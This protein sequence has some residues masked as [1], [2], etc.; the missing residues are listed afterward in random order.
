MYATGDAACWT[1]DGEI[2]LAGRF[3]R[4]VKLRGLRVEPQE[5]AD[6]IA[7]YPGGQRG[8]CKKYVS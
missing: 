1:Q 8:G 3:D 2:L 6:C 7:S 4:Q 5:I